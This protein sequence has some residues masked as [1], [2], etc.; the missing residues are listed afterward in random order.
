M[1]FET[2]YIVTE[3]M[4]AESMKQYFLEVIMRSRPWKQLGLLILSA[5]LVSWGLP[6]QMTW[7]LTFY[8]VFA[9]CLVAIWIKSYALH[10]RVARDGLRLLDHPKIVVSLDDVQIEYVS[11]TGTRRF[12]W[13]KI[14]KLHE[15]RD[16]MVLMSGR[17]PLLTLPKLSF[18]E[19]VRGFMK[20]KI[21][22]H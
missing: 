13:D 8:G 12:Q 5:A 19:E 16:F 21:Q 9:A 6:K 2:E 15:T 3:Q 7:V 14:D 11:A 1:K 18:S 4:Q 20:G 17:L 22:Q 10:Q